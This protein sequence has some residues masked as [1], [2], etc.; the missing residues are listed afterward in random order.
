M[1]INLRKLYDLAPL[2]IW[3]GL[4]GFGDHN[5]RYFEQHTQ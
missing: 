3:L 2:G 1:Q 5:S 4:H